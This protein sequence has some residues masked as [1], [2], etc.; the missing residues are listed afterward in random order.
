MERHPVEQVL[1]AEGL[2]KVYR[3][4][5]VEVPALS[6]IDL[7]LGDRRNAVRASAQELVW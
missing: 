7:T 5:Q 4:G 6:G 2:T 3:M 1:G